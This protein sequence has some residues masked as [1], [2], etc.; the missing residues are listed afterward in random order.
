MANYLDQY[1]EY[2]SQSY[3]L[4]SD[5]GLEL[6]LSIDN[7]ELNNSTVNELLGY[8]FFGRN[9]RD[10]Q[11]TEDQRLDPLTAMVNQGPLLPIPIPLGFFG[12][13]NIFPP[14]IP[15]LLSHSQLLNILGPGQLHLDDT[16][17]NKLISLPFNYGWDDIVGNNPLINAPLAAIIGGLEPAFPASGNPARYLNGNKAFSQ[18]QF[19]HLGG[20]PTTLAGYG[21]SSSDTLFDG[22]YLRANT[23]LSTY[24]LGSNTP[25]NNTL[26]TV[27]MFGNVQAQINA[28]EAALGNPSTNGYIL[29]STTAGVRS[30]VPFAGGGT[31]NSVSIN[32]L[33]GFAGTAVVTT[34]NAA[35]T[36]RTSVTGILIGNGTAISAATEMTDYIGITGAN[37]GD[38]IVYDGTAGVATWAP[39]L[40]NPMDTLGDIIYGL[41]LGATAKL[42]GNITTTNK[43]LRSTGD[44]TLATAP[45]WQALV[46]GDIPNI[47]ISQVTNLQDTLDGYLPDALANDM[48]FIGNVSDVAVNAIVTGDLTAAYVD[49]SGTNEAQFTIANEAV[50]YAKIQNVTSQTLLGRFALTDGVVQQLTLNGSDF[51]INSSTGVIGLATPNSPILTTKGDILTHTGAAQVRLGIGANATFFMADTAATTGNKWVAMSGD[52]TIAVSGAL[53]I[54]A[55]VVT[56]GKMANLAANSFIGN[57]T[58]S[59]ATPIALTVTQATAMLNL[60]S[61]SATTKGLVPGSNSVGA[62]Y[63]LDATGAWSVPAGGGGGGSG[64]VSSGTQYQLA[65]YA[66]NGTTVSGLT[67]I[68]ASRALVS[69]AN[70]L[71]IASTVSTTQLQYL[72][73]ATGTTGTTSTNLVFSTSPTLVTPT[74]GAALATSINGLTITSTTGTLTLDNGSTLATSGAFSTTL[75]AT[76][77]TTL[78]LPTTGTLATLAGTETFTNKTLNGPK[79]GTVGGQGHFHLHFANSAPTG[80]TD[81]ITVFGDVAPTKKLGFFF[82]LDA[83]ESYFQ[84]NATTAS[85]TY[86]FPDATGT[87]ALINASNYLSVPKS[88]AVSGGI[89]FEGGT[90]GTISFEAPLIAGTQS[91]IFPSAY[92]AASSGYYLTS[93]DTGTLSWN[94]ITGGGD[95]T[96]PSGA[97]DGDF[98]V[99]SGTT[100]KI[101]AEPTTASFNNSTGRATFNGGVDLGVSGPTSGTTGTLVFRN[102]TTAATTTLQASTSQSANLSYTWP[103]VAPTAGQILSS[104]INGNLSW[105]AAGAGDM[106]LAGTQTVT[107][108]KTFNAGAIRINNA[109]NN[110]YHI[111]ASL[112]AASGTLTATFPAATGTVPLLSLAQTFTA[113]QTFQNGVAL[114]TGGTFTTAAAVAST[115]SGSVTM[116]A[117]GSVSSPQLSFTAGGGTTNWINFANTGAAAPTAVTRSTGTRFVF[118]QTVGTNSLDYAIGLGSNEVWLSTSGTSNLISFYV[119]TATNVA[120]RLGSFTGNGLTLAAPGLAATP[121]LDFSGTTRN[122]MNFSTAGFASPANGATAASRSTGTRIVFSQ[123]LGAS[124]FDYAI[125][126]GSAEMWFSVDSAVNTFGFY[127]GTSRIAFFGGGAG[128]GLTLAGTLVGAASQDVFNTVSTT[129]NFAGAAT[130]LAVGNVATAAQTVNMFTAS[131]G[132]STYNFAT[133]ATL[134]A[135]TKTINIGTAGVSGSTTVVNIGSAVAGATNTIAIRGNLTLGTSGGN[136]GFWGTAAVARQT[137]TSDTLANL[138]TAL[139]AYGLI[140]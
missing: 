107:G 52:A 75:T 44:G 43:F 69:D 56:L 39:G 101:I 12:S 89:I 31:L 60:F 127:A 132:A 134:A 61:T 18:V 118:A 67:L 10:L 5:I 121:Q 81:Y 131:T 92:P 115:F 7:G 116:S 62:T 110:G 95:V 100:G 51:T 15:P 42:A 37:D 85:K 34:G 23:V 65:Y 73:S 11:A 77:T 6:A 68:T 79:I 138:Y 14:S 17:L 41:A 1:K 136:M 74:L 120:L 20:V 80:L 59:A 26:S 29:S 104:D 64:T 113:A 78:T 123:T 119:G 130:T 109:T 135:T 50:T 55:G 66:A 82:E 137:I 108:T 86:T 102:A 4:I 128:V 88:G 21:I 9:V 117:V 48:L 99:F 32:S 22:R 40:F 114:N 49:N 105:T 8:V 19:S 24:S 90:S 84:F 98:V 33:N 35:I 112:A 28:R 126:L 72:A 124:S 3:K 133:G 91:Y 106:T 70:G 83:F 71:P 76:A 46:A 27:Q 125:G 54:E 103:I 53:T 57:N 36:L 96:G 38:T 2:L 47:A 139:R 94:L 16:L 45:S 140:L 30:W 97:T 129:V 25:I 87:V 111:L 122:W 58:G 63:Y 13:V 93:T